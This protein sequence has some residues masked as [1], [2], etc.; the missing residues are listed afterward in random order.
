MREIGNSCTYLLQ[1]QWLPLRGLAMEDGTPTTV[2]DGDLADDIH[3]LSIIKLKQLIDKEKSNTIQIRRALDNIKDVGM[4]IY[5]RAALAYYDLCVNFEYSSKVLTPPPDNTIPAEILL[6]KARTGSI[7]DKPEMSM[8][9][10]D[11]HDEKALFRISEI[12]M[13]SNQTLNYIKNCMNEKQE[14]LKKKG[15]NN[16]QL[17]MAIEDIIERW[18]KARSWYKDLYKV[19]NKMIDY[20]KRLKP[21]D[22]F[23]SGLKIN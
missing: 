9:F 17:R 21:G 20:K 18:K 14:Q 1:I 11:A 2:T 7:F 19:T 5:Q 15:K 4:K 22:K 23:K 16:E 10:K 6:S 3:P 12:N 13:Y 8:V